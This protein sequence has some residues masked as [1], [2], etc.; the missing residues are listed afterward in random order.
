[1]VEINNTKGKHNTDKSK[2]HQ[3]TWHRHKN[4]TCK[5]V[6]ISIVVTLDPS[7]CCLRIHWY[8]FSCQ[9]ETE[10]T[11]ITQETKQPNSRQRIQNPNTP[12]SN[13][14]SSEQQAIWESEQ[15]SNKF[16]QKP[17]IKSKS[18]IVRSNPNTVNIN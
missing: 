14:Y 15:C 8:N 17:R 9:D 13:L 10:A 3:K 1:M 4:N 7:C 12:N 11:L 6:T 5:W 16:R 18:E 2:K